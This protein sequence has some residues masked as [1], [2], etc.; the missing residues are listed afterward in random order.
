GNKTT[1]ILVLVE[2]IDA[3]ASL[4]IQS[5]MTCHSDENSLVDEE[6]D[7]QSH[8]LIIDEMA[9][10]ILFNFNAGDVIL[11]NDKK[12]LVSSCVNFLEVYIPNGPSHLNIMENSSILCSL[13]KF[14]RKSI[15]LLTKIFNTAESCVRFVNNDILSQAVDCLRTILPQFEECVE[16][17]SFKLVYNYILIRPEKD[18]PIKRNQTQ[19]I[20][21]L[22][23]V[24]IL[25]MLSLEFQ[26]YLKNPEEKSQVSEKI[27]EDLSY[28]LA[29]CCSGKNSLA[30]STCQHSILHETL[31]S[32]VNTKKTSLKIQSAAL[33]ILYNTWLEPI[34]TIKQPADIVTA[35]ADRKPAKNMIFKEIYKILSS[36]FS[37]FDQVS[38]IDSEASK[39][40]VNAIIP[41]IN[42]LCVKFEGYKKDECSIYNVLDESFDF[43]VE[44][45]TK[46]KS[47]KSKREIFKFCKK[48]S[49]FLSNDE[50]RKSQIEFKKQKLINFKQEIGEFCE[51]S[52]SFLES[53]PKGNIIEEALLIQENFA[54]FFNN[55][56]KNELISAVKEE[57]RQLLNVFNITEVEMKEGSRELPRS[58]TR[59][60]IK[61]INE[62]LDT[63]G[64][65]FERKGDFGFINS[66]ISIIRGLV[67]RVVKKINDIKENGRKVDL[68]AKLKQQRFEL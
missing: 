53:P 20:Q 29:A 58:P 25:H 44:S 55:V 13:L 46:I 42:L 35:F 4:C 45:M 36:T 16:K 51:S 28:L 60:L 12:K 65:E 61:L 66:N 22:A 27:I 17:D 68:D 9:R 30:I 23:D 49:E 6:S 1:L 31:F 3:L 63:D 33:S 50:I 40:I 26:G 32:I 15:S 34:I 37:M 41:L 43:L 39:Y 38:K 2:N 11:N 5:S 48:L 47:L 57:F 7:I 59:M 10:R 18:V 24:G 56:F 62:R 64:D 21:K 52:N 8:E 14:E 54:S 67:D 19:L